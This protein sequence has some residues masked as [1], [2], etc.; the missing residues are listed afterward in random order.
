MAKQSRVRASEVEAA[1]DVGIGDAGLV[2]AMRQGSSAAFREFLRRFQPFLL[3]QARR[4]GV[5]PDDLEDSVADLLGDAATRL[6]RSVTPPP[7]SLAAYL[8]TAFRRR[9]LNLLRSG[10]RRAHWHGEAAS[11]DLGDGPAVATAC[12]ESA[13]RASRGPG[14]ESP[15][16]PPVLLRLAHTLDDTLTADERLLLVWVGHHVPQREIARWLG[17]S[18]A[19]ATQRIWRL[20]ER[21]REEAL[22]HVAALPLP[23]RAVAE[24]FFARAR[25]A[26]REEGRMAHER[27]EPDTWEE[28]A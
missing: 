2:A 15:P 28:R 3:A 7:R 12:S 23:E 26:E 16:L 27:T 1:G 25:R 10:S 5:H 19:A 17:V 24:R 14:W 20:R 6:A 13:L 22:T 11:E 18:Y 9:L 21:L 4:S 8:L